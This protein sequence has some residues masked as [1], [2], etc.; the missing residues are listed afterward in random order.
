MP[1]EVSLVKNIYI[2]IVVFRNIHFLFYFFIFVFVFFNS[3]FVLFVGD[4][5]KVLVLISL[6]P[7]GSLYRWMSLLCRACP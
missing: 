5:V 3:G 2:I 4:S 7:L 1:L 6:S